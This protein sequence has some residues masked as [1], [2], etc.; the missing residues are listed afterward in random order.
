MSKNIVDIKDK[1]NGNHILRLKTNK[2]ID[3][4]LKDKKKFALNLLNKQKMIKTVLEKTGKV[5]GRL[6]KIQT[7]Y[8]AG[9]KT[10]EVL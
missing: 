10:K 4:K 6:R 7:K 3:F 2:I 9:V 5:K 1:Y 8:L